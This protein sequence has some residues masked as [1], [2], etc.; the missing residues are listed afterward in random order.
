MSGQTHSL[1]IN[2][3][4]T[5]PHESAASF[6]GSQKTDGFFLFMSRNSRQ[7]TRKCCAIHDH[8]A[9]PCTTDPSSMSAACLKLFPLLV[10]LFGA[11]SSVSD[12][13]FLLDSSLLEPRRVSMDN[14][15]PARMSIGILDIAQPAVVIRFRAILT[16][17][18]KSPAPRM[19]IPKVT[20][21]TASDTDVAT[22]SLLFFLFAGPLEEADRCG[23]RSSDSKLQIVAP[24]TPN[25]MVMVIIVSANMTLQTC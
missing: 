16:P 15:D 8:C 6:H 7:A 17:A 24:R 25:S 20:E 4:A 14:L 11:A 12:P 19:V 9:F 3:I 1:L 5:A 23:F 13:P 18:R 21:L 10:S 22:T 2:R